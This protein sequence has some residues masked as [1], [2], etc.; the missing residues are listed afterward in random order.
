MQAAQ[1]EYV[2]I[3]HYTKYNEV[4]TSISWEFHFDA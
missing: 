4:S 1:G 3:S 2:V